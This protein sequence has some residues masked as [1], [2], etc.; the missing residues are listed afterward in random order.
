MSNQKKSSIDY[1]QLL[2]TL[3]EIYNIHLESPSVEQTI[4]NLQNSYGITE[5]EAKSILRMSINLHNKETQF[6]SRA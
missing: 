4:T 1:T 6:S 2:N 3:R 5:E